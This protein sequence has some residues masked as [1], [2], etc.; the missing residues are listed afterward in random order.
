MLT[1]LFTLLRI[2]G[3]RVGERG[4]LYSA[5]APPK[6]LSVSDQNGQECGLVSLRAAPSALHYKP[7]SGGRCCPGQCQGYIPY[8]QRDPFLSLLFL[9]W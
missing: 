3:S 2:I 9:I 6:T 7:H 5:C 4:S 1:C 8:I